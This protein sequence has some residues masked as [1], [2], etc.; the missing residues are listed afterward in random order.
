MANS[1]SEMDRLI[2]VEGKLEKLDNRFD[3]LERDVGILKSDVGIL[4]S[5]GGVLKSAVLQLTEI[6]VE[7]SEKLSSMDRTLQ[8][9]NDRLARLLN[10]NLRERTESIERLARVEKVAS[11]DRLDEI[12]RR[13]TRLEERNRG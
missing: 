13:L 5:D 8:T 1:P 7:H 2:S 9:I 6:A 12:E 11:E 10:V 4:K 3:G